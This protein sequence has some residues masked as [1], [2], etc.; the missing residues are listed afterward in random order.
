MISRFLERTLMPDMEASSCC[1]GAAQTAAAL[2]LGAVDELLL[3]AGYLG[4]G[5]TVDDW[6][7]LASRH[8]ATVVEIEPHSEQAVSFC[9]NYGVGACLRWVVEPSLLEGEE[10]VPK[11]ACADPDPASNAPPMPP[12]VAEASLEAGG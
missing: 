10:E 8:G 5:L 6:K 9:A 11:T 2:K 1:Y 7:D 12:A 4:C 3:A